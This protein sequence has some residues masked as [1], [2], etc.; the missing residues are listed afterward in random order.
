MHPFFKQLAPFFG[1]SGI[2]ISF[3]FLKTES[4]FLTIYKSVYRYTFY[5]FLIN[6][7]YFD[8]IYNFFSKRLYD[9][10]YYNFYKLFDKGIFEFFGPRGSVVS[11]NKISEIF[12]LTQSGYIWHYMCIMV[13]FLVIICYI[14]L[15]SMPEII[16]HSLCFIILS[17]KNRPKNIKKFSQS[18]LNTAA[19]LPPS[20]NSNT[21][22]AFIKR[23]VKTQTFIFFIATSLFTYRVWTKTFNAYLVIEAWIISLFIYLITWT[24]FYERLISTNT[25]AELSFE[26]YLQ[27]KHWFWR[28]KF[29]ISVLLQFVFFCIFLSSSLCEFTWLIF[30]SRIFTFLL[31]LYIILF[32]GH[33]YFAFQ[34]KIPGH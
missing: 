19:S 2:F 31:V 9:F 23:I 10:N 16:S 3:Y 25:A 6:K 1:M 14:F 34:K 7:W 22:L 13:I 5:K 32:I 27:T 24:P 17:I 20:R 28:K 11:I 30:F 8:N 15:F 12:I 18:F 21:F 29:L 33:L 26:E 4:V